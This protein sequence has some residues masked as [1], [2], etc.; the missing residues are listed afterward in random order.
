MSDKKQELKEKFEQIQWDADFARA[1]MEAGGD[2][3]HAFW[4]MIDEQELQQAVNIL[5][6]LRDRIMRELEGENVA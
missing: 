5:G 2:H 3:E 1:C 6:L 4:L